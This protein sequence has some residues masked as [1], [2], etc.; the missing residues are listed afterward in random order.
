MDVLALPYSM[1]ARLLSQAA[2]EVRKSL[3]E[4]L[5]P[6]KGMSRK[7]GCFLLLYN[8]V[9]RSKHDRG[10]CWHSTAGTGHM[11]KDMLTA[12]CRGDIACM[13]EGREP[14]HLPVEHYIT[15]AADLEEYKAALARHTALLGLAAKYLIDRKSSST[16]EQRLK[17]GFVSLMDPKSYMDY[18]HN[19]LAHLSSGDRAMLRCAIGARGDAEKHAGLPG[20]GAAMEVSNV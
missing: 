3:P 15:D 7:A 6:A 20:V 18:H 9:D 16:Q 11:T 12:A 5:L 4:G 10:S 14:V 2:R 17:P 13:L 19:E 8:V 1:R